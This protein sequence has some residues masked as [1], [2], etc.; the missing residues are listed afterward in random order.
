MGQR[1]YFVELLWWRAVVSGAI[2]YRRV[3]QTK[4]WHCSCITCAGHSPKIRSTVYL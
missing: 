2:S 4:L 3:E 1:Y